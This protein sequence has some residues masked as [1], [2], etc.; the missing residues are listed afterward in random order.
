MLNLDFL[1]LLN[2]QKSRRTNAKSD[3]QIYAGPTRIRIAAIAARIVPRYF[4]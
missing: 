1:I 3:T 4:K 2:T